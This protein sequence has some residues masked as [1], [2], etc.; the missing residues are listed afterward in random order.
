MRILFQLFVI[1][2]LDIPYIYIYG[3][4]WATECLLLVSNKLQVKW[5][6]WVAPQGIII[7]NWEATLEKKL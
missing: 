1:F 4:K 2:F 6:N 3:R 5:Q 7:V